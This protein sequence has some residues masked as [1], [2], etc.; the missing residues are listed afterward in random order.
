MKKVIIIGATSGIGRE[1]ANLFSKNRYA[2]G[3]TGRRDAILKEMQQ[4]LPGEIHT[5]CMDISDYNKASEQLN[6][7]IQEMGGVDIIVVSAGTG[8][9]NPDLLWNLEEETIMVNVLG[10]SSI[11]NVAMHHF[12][13]K[14]EGQLVGISSIAAIRGS[15]GGPSYSASKAF[16][17]NYLE[18]L[19]CFAFKKKSNITVTEIQPGFVDT[20]MAKGDGLFWVLTYI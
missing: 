19:R 2:V 12:I 18:G 17:S 5:K 1:L 6:S 3:I 7:L 14:G 13:E 16:V 10:F 9:I 15:A 8:H 20:D 11:C 4:N